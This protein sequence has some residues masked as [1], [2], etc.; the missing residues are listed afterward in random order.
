M[1]LGTLFRLT[2]GGLA[3]GR[4]AL[5]LHQGSTDAHSQ[6][7]ATGYLAG[8]MRGGRSTGTLGVTTDDVVMHVQ[9][10]TGAVSMHSV[11]ASTINQATT[12][13]SSAYN[14]G[15]NGTLSAA[16]TT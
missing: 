13:A 8:V 3:N 9:S 12:S 15:F 6:V 1:A 11:I 7:T 16:V 4:G 10:G 14:F 2:P 5:W